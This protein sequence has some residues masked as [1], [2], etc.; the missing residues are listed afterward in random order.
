MVF[1]VCVCVAL[2]R[3]FQRM[4]SWKACIHIFK[5]VEKWDNQQNNYK[6]GIAI[7]VR[8]YGGDACTFVLGH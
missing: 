5:K 3:N 6:F 7:C 8:M 4:Q 2:H 1:G